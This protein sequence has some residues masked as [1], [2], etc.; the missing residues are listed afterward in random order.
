MP[1]FRGSAARADAILVPCR[2]CHAIIGDPCVNTFV[3]GS[4]PLWHFVAHQCRVADAA[5]TVP[6]IDTEEVPF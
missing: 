1:D 5:K 6:P 4:P 2:Y 3:E